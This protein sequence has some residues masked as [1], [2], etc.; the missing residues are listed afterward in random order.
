MCVVRESGDRRGL[1][2]FLRT[3]AVIP[4]DRIDRWSS[5]VIWKNGVYREK[6]EVDIFLE[7]GS[8]FCAL[9]YKLGAGVSSWC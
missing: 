5:G 7:T 8:L 4:W 6:S 2:I 1:Y 3:S 9:R